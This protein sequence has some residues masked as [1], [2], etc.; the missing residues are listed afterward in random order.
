[1]NP[2]DFAKL[3]AAFDEHRSARQSTLTTP[4][5][6]SRQPPTLLDPTLQ[7]NQQLP[8]H[9]GDNGQFGQYSVAVPHPHQSYQSQHMGYI[10]PPQGVMRGYASQSSQYP[11]PVLHQPPAL[12]NAYMYGDAMYAQPAGNQLVFADYPPPHRRPQMRGY[13]PSGHQA[14]ANTTQDANTDSE[15]VQQ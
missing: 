15:T 4:A 14:V 10:P 6:P 2:E 11:M 7:T 8:A 5:L 12:G 9:F 13:A 3:S 1:M